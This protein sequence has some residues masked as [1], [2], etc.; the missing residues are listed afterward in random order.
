MQS[1]GGDHAEVVRRTMQEMYPGFD[2]T[3]A[4]SQKCCRGCRVEICYYRCTE[5][6]RKENMAKKKEVT[7]VATAPATTMVDEN[8]FYIRATLLNTRRDGVEDLLDKM[9][10]MGFFTAPASGGNHLHMEGGLAQHSMNVA[11]A[12]EKVGLAL[13]GAEAYNQI[14]N[15]VLTC[16]LLHDLGKCGDWGKALYVENILKTGKRSEAKPYKRNPE[17]TNIPHGVR[18]VLIA[19]KYLFDLTEDEEYAIM[20]HDG[21]YE[22]SNVAVVKGHESVL[23]MILHWA[24]MWASKVM[25][26]GDDNGED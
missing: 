21:L 24:D 14:H 22:P 7:E 12:A 11:R 17:L 4:C 10:E 13:L 6:E 8:R 1:C 5:C 9:D 20:Y 15:S 18:S 23:Y 2:L 19:E 16:A 3:P 26:G 25:E